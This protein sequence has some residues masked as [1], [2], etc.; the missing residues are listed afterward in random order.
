[1]NNIVSYNPK[2]SVIIPVYNVEKYIERCA[3]SLLEQSLKDIEY[4]FVD[5]CSPDNSI[6]MLENLLKEY[7][8]RQPLVKILFH[9]PNRGLAYT[10]QEGVDAAKGE[11]II[12]CDSDDWVEPEMYETMYNIA[13]KQNADIV[14]CN[15]FEEYNHWHKRVEYSYLYETPEILLASIPTTLNSAVWNKLIRRTL[16][17]ANNIRWFEGINMQEDLGITLRLRVLSLKTIVVPYAFYHY[18]RQNLFSMAMKPKLNYIEEQ[19]LCAKLLEQWMLFHFNDRYKYLVDKIKFWAKSGLFIHSGIQDIKRWKSTFPETNINIWRYKQMPLY[20]RLP[21]WLALHGFCSL[22]KMIV[23]IKN[24]L[25]YMR[26]SI[27]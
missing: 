26:A 4:I 22:A 20:N 7:P 13:I 23:Y 11:Y 3:R 16:Y 17:I 8:E 14:C 21:M 10:R 24:K 12:H 5:D 25:A 9:E 15:Y 27:R 19:I 2:V 18:N 6:T 1:M